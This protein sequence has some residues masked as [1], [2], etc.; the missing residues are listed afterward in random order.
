MIPLNQWDETRLAINSLEMWEKGNYLVTTFNYQP[1]MWNTKPPLMIWL[2]SYCINIFG[3]SLFAIRFPSLLSGLITAVLLYV[4]L[5]KQT[6]NKILA[7]IA[8]IILIGS[9]GFMN[10]HNVRSGDYDALLTLFITIYIYHFYQ[11]LQND[12]LKNL[13]YFGLFFI[14]AFLTKGIAS[15]MMLPGLFLLTLFNRKFLNVV[16]NKYVYFTALS[17]LVIFISY[18]VLRELFNHGYIEA[19]IKNEFSGRF[20]EVN[21]GHSEPFY[22][23]LLNIWQDRFNK[24]LLIIIV[25]SIPFLIKSENIK[26]IKNLGILIITFLLVISISKTKLYWYDMPVY[27]LLS[28]LS[29]I[30]LYSIIEKFSK[31]YNSNKYLSILIICIFVF[32][33][34]FNT[35]NFSLRNQLFE[36]ERNDSFHI[37]NYLQ[38]LSEGEVSY[39]PRFVVYVNDFYNADQEFYFHILEK[40]GINVKYAIFRDHKNFDPYVIT[41]LNS[42]KSDLENKYNVEV[43]KIDKN[44]VYFLKLTEKSK[45]DVLKQFKTDL[46]KYN[47][48]GIKL[49]TSQKDRKKIML[50]IDK[51]LF[52]TS[53]PISFHTVETI[54]STEKFLIKDIGNWDGEDLNQNESY[55]IITLEGDFERV[56]IGQNSTENPSLNWEEWFNKY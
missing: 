36:Y 4:F 28:T 2:Q 31:Y 25:I 16:K 51:K 27:P 41:S 6:N 19:V 40:K 39:D 38:Q 3:P 35:L 29:A 17:C 14:L 33:G 30:C 26:L 5:N 44:Q 24:F 54:N 13:L 43:L 48:K 12:S 8:P 10:P 52:N 1:D 32:P 11:F 20:L 7:I 45:N 22:Y 21:E 56:A 49:V 42:I 18:Y 9:L 55:K 34:Y 46:S 53:L 15:C 37:N 23:Y 50:I 47:S